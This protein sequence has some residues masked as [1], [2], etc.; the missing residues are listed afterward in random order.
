MMLYVMRHG[1]AV[2]RGDPDFPDDARRPL[3]P[4][5]RRKTRAAA[6]GLRRLKPE[7]DAI[8]SSPLARALQTAEIVAAELRLGP[9]ALRQTAA[10]APGA[11]RGDLL[12]ELSGA[13]ANGDAPR[14]ILVV[15][16]EPDLSNLVAYLLTGDSDGLDLT[17][18]KAAIAAL[19]MPSLSPVERATL[20]WFLQP[21]QLRAIGRGV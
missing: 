8:Y 20:V 17:L 14:G 16:H 18:K 10:L 11:P 12:R 3:T 1:V 5:G 2:E 21:R 15:G 7:I 6:R 9:P 13:G 4:D 19:E